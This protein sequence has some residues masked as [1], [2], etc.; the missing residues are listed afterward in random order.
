M[1]DSGVLKDIFGSEIQFVTLICQQDVVKNS[2]S[3][4]Y[5]YK[6]GSKAAALILTGDI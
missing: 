3:F 4:F 2:L 5:I 6:T 1:Y